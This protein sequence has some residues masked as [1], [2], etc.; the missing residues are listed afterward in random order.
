MKIQPFQL[1]RYFAQYEFS[2]PYLL[3][4]SDCEPFTWKSCWR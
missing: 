3:S 1:E 4:P 2:A